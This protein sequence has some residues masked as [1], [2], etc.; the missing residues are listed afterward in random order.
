MISWN[1][2]PK[3]NV[4]DRPTC[5]YDVCTSYSSKQSD[6]EK[7]C[8]GKFL[9]KLFEIWARS[10]WPI[11]N[12]EKK[13]GWLWA[14]FESIFFLFSVAK[15]VNFFQKKKNRSVCTKKLH[16]IKLRKLIYDD[17]ALKGV[18]RKTW[19]AGV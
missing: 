16:K 8:G 10:F 4:S 6:L 14:S 1:Y 9:G 2:T 19:I 3:N 17:F 5:M 11:R 7:S 18:L 15:K 13:M 12:T